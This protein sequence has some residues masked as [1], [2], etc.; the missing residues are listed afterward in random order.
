VIAF[1]LCH[2]DTGWRDIVQVGIE[3]LRQ[4]NLVE[5]VHVVVF[6]RHVPRHVRLVQTAGE[7]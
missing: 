2:A 4:L 3:H 1:G 6:L 7:K 5:R